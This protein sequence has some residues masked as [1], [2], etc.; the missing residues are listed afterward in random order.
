MAINPIRIPLHKVKLSY[1]VDLKFIV[2]KTIGFRMKL[3]TP[4]KPLEIKV[5]WM[6]LAGE[7][8]LSVYYV[9]VLPPVKKI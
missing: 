3:K 8:V 1:L 4:L 2:L 7:A 6:I 9:Y 5:F